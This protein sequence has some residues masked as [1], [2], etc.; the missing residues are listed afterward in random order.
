MYRTNTLFTYIM[1]YCRMWF[2]R[3]FMNE[4]VHS[5]FLQSFTR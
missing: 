5:S 4:Q 2:S 3:A 1:C